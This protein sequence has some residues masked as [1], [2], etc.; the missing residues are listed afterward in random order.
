MRR[1][2]AWGSSTREPMMQAGWDMASQKS[3]RR[4]HTMHTISQSR[5][6]GLAAIVGLSAALLNPGAGRAQT[7]DLAPAST[8]PAT[9]HVMGSGGLGSP[10]EETIIVLAPSTAPS[11]DGTSG[12]GSVEASRA[13]LAPTWD[14]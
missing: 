12:Y 4:E 6:A 8:L 2:C 7:A 3:S 14:E 11:W 13:A 5:L 10:Y 1:C 9:G